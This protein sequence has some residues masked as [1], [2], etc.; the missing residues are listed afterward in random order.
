VQDSLNTVHPVK[1]VLFQLQYAAGRGPEELPFFWC[2]ALIGADYCLCSEAARQ[3][4]VSEEHYISACCSGS[5]TVALSRLSSENKKPRSCG[6]SFDF[7]SYGNGAKMHRMTTLGLYLFIGPSPN[8]DRSASGSIHLAKSRHQAYCRTGSYSWKDHW[9]TRA[10]FLRSCRHRSWCFRWNPWYRHHYQRLRRHPPP[11]RLR[12][13][14]VQVQGSWSVQ[15]LQ[16]A[17]MWIV[18]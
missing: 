8:Q 17:R 4:S 9:P 6:A 10:C 5:R 15:A 18:S 16:P 3:T 14:L 1:D 13:P 11:R 7:S 2:H 12:H